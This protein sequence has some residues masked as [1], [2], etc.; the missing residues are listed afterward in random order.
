MKKSR[1]VFTSCSHRLGVPC[2]LLAGFLASAL[3][4]CAAAGEQTIAPARGEI[5]SDIGD[6]CWYVFQD[7]DDNYW[8][9]SDGNGV[10]RYDGKTLTRYTTK[11][12]LAHDHVRGIQQHGPTGDILIT[13][14]AGVSRFDGRRLLTLPIKEMKRA[15]PP[16]EGWELNRDDVWMTGAGGPR[17]YDGKTL[18]QL[19]FPQSPLEESLTARI[20][21]KDNWSPYDVWTVYA[22]RKGHKWFGTGMFGISR[23]DGKHIDWMFEPH[24]T[25]V[26]G[27]G[28]FGFRSIIEDRDGAF[29]FC[30]TQFRFHVQPH[31][32]AGQEAGLLKYVRTP[33]VDSAVIPPGE[34]PIYY[35]GVVSDQAGDLWMATYGFGVWRCDG[36]KMTHYPIMDGNNVVKL[37]S[38]FKDNQGGLW[39]GTHEHGAYRFNGKTF[40]RFRI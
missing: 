35:Q 20:P 14:N 1:S 2:L 37:I 7:K 5:V 28:W 32:V 25:E 27:A 33:G 13:T 39:L 6:S 18:Y 15:A 29:W 4:G 30:N 22:D 21:H 16:S 10:C 24:L 8:F 9:G 26:P 17:R 31:G 11:D 12:G 23:F 40:E 36:K 3:A 38:I 19:K 34:S